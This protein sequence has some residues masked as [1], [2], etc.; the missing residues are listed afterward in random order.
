MKEYRI[1]I[2]KQIRAF[3]SKVFESDFDL[4]PTHISLYM[5]LLN[6][7]NRSNWIE[8]FKCPFDTIMMGASINSNKTYY[9][10]LNDLVELKLIKYKPGINLYK[11]P[12]IH[13][14][15]LYENSD[16]EDIVPTPEK[17]SSVLITQLTTLLNTQ[18]TTQLTTQQCKQLCKQLWQ[19]KDILITNNYKINIYT[20]KKKTNFIYNE[21]YDEQLKSSNEDKNF[22]TFIK[23]IF[24]INEDKK[25]LKGVLSIRDQL[26]YEQFKKCLE[27]ANEKKRSLTSILLKIE[28]DKKYY[29][30]KVSLNRTLQ[31]WL[32][33]TFIK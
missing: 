25:T 12:K 15:K 23:V 33:Q 30:G 31:N 10:I 19:H 22:E 20:P 5:F 26:T 13:I 29:K 2:Y 1:N 27:I 3:Y 6:Q 4:K 14:I 16:N 17:D 7:N 9:R 24:G 21:F 11:A 32:N 28:N 8:W 18:L